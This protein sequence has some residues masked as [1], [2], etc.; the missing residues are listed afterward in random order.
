MARSRIPDPIEP[1][2]I[3]TLTPRPARRAVAVALQVLLGLILIW[4]G[5]ILPGGGLLPKIALL[6]GG[7]AMLAGA[8][9]LWQAT[10]SRIELTSEC[11]SDSEGR[12]LARIENIRA[13]D[14]GAFAFK[15]SNGF[16]LHLDHRAPR[17]WVPGLWWRVGRFV[18][19]GGATPRNEGKAMA[20]A[21]A[22]LLAERAPPA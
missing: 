15:P 8:L 20:E 19:V 13:V 10:A 14:R 3:A 18:G 22:L 2:I 12:I 1:P 5:A 9:R 6:L 4:L 17:A 21:V 11:L 16:L 7:G